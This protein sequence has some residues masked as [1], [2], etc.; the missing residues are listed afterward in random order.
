MINLLY[1]E[2]SLSDYVEFTYTDVMNFKRLAPSD[3]LNL[4]SYATEKV[5]KITDI[6]TA[7]TAQKNLIATQNTFTAENLRR[8]AI[9]LAGIVNELHIPTLKKRYYFL[10]KGS[11]IAWVTGY[12]V[13]NISEKYKN[14]KE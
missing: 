5:N 1:P 8:G 13:S 9:L 4:I 7:G 3:Y 2:K 12:I 11:H 14:A 6:E 10:S